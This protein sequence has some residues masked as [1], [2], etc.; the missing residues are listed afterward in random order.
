MKIEK[1]LNNLL[2]LSTLY[3]NVGSAWAVE[4]VEDS[5]SP[6]WPLIV[7]LV[8]LIIFRKKLIA[9]ATVQKQDA[10]HSNEEKVPQQEE[11]KISGDNSEDVT[12]LTQN[13]EQ[14]QGTTAKGA[15]CSRSSNLEPVIVN[16]ENKKYQFLSCKQHHNDDFTPFHFR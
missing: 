6:Y 10:V 9:E 8:V 13:V 11:K 3:L 1:L 16:I 2:I 15:R 5:G 4:N 14:C 12:D 7:L